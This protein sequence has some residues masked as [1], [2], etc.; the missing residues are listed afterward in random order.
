MIFLHSPLS[1]AF[2][3]DWISP[4][5]SESSTTPEAELFNNCYILYCTRIVANASRAL[6]D[7][8]MAVSYEQDAASLASAIHKKFFV[9]ASASYLDTRQ[10]HLVMP[11]L[12]GAVPA[13]H[14]DRVWA[15]LRTEIVETQG[16]HLDTGLHGTY[17]MTKLLTD[18]SMGFG[19]HDEL[20]YLYTTQTTHPGYGDLLRKGF[21][22]RFCF[23]G[24][25][26]I[27]CA[28]AL[29]DMCC[30]IH[31][32]TCWMLSRPGQK[33]GVATPTML[34]SPGS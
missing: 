8:A 4:H 11:L 28:Q 6:G 2:L 33:A 19:E 25:N 18:T 1:Q 23:V 7:E 12:A 30:H 5:G 13:E 16:G 10:T 3:G 34:A 17:F 32:L 26:T 31:V 15:A 14:T 9:A 20:I 21:T 22:V 24:C 29:N 27:F